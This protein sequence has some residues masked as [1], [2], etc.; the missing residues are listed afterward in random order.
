M[1][2]A[3]S[4]AQAMFYP[5]DDDHQNQELGYYRQRE[6]RI[7]ADYYVNGSPRGRGLTDEEKVL[8]L[9]LDERFWGRRA[10]SSREL[11]RVDEALALVQP[12]PRELIGMVRRFI[13]PDDF[14]DKAKGIF[15]DRVT[16]IRELGESQ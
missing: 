9:G 14:V 5:T 15:G 2:G 16:T 11:R 4:I 13:V 1:I 10:H 8:L 7:T 12:A 6:W 3:A